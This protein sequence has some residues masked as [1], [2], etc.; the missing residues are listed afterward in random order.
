M[1]LLFRTAAGAAL[2]AVA[3]AAALLLLYG[4]HATVVFDPAVGAVVR[5]V[6]GVERSPQGEFFWAGPEATLALGGLDR[7]VSWSCTIRMRGA[8]EDPATLPH[9]AAI[10]DGHAIAQTD[11][12]NDFRDWTFVL[13]SARGVSR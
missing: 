3:A 6:Y 9:L 11:A 10:V 4:R 5:G 7:R 13:P 1:R 2:G 8:R 12:A